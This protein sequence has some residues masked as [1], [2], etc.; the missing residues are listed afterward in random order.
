M[1]YASIARFF[2]LFLFLILWIESE[3]ST[4]L[5]LLRILRMLERQMGI[6]FIAERRV[7]HWMNRDCKRI[8]NEWY[9]TCICV[10]INLYGNLILRVKMRRKHFAACARDRRVSF[11]FLSKFT[12]CWSI[13][14]CNFIAG[15][16][17]NI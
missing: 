13:K 10:Y 2:L 8:F 4:H 15:E 5:K 12:S 11:N 6:F 14:F 1:L 3:Y 17:S 16:I 9:V 7:L